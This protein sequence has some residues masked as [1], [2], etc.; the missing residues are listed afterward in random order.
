MLSGIYWTRVVL[1]AIASEVGVIAAL[2]AAIA[3]YKWA[4]PPT[5]KDVEGHTLGEQVGY[6]VAP[7]AGA[8]TTFLVA[9]WAAR[10]GGPRYLAHGLWVG[11]LSVLLAL[12]FAIT[13]KREHRVMYGIAFALRLI[14]GVLG[15]LLAQ[16]LATR[17]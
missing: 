11:A 9:V 7:T 10:G 13:A 12:G 15:G 5:W 14:A 8:I 2:L 6:Y 17:A 3:V 1:A 16:Q 4:A